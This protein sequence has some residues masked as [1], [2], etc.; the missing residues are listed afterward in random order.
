MYM[1]DGSI[2][3]C[4]V[5]L[6]LCRVWGSNPNY[7]WLCSPSNSQWRSVSSLFMLPR[8]VG[9]GLQFVFL[10]AC[11]SSTCVIF[12]CSWWC[13]E[14]PS[15]KVFRI[16]E[17]RQCVYTGS[18]MEVNMVIKITFQYDGCPTLYSLHQRLFPDQTDIGMASG[19]FASSS[20]MLTV[21]LWF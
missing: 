9:S 6:N 2:T 18:W 21:S 15:G 7:Y 14:S 13:S 1:V 8:H 19:L 20:V 3:W 11:E 17:G 5:I 4:C 12:F 10:P 16:W